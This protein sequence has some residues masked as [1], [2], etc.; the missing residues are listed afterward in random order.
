[1][2]A[3]AFIASTG[4]SQDS[5]GPTRQRY[6]PAYYFGTQG[7]PPQVVVFPPVGAPVVIPLPIPDLLRFRA[8]TRDGRQ[9]FATI[10][11]ITSPGSPGHPARLGPPRL[12]R[13]DFGP[14][15]VTPVADLVGLDDVLGLVVT[16]HQ[17][18]ILFA[19]AGWKGKIGCD[20]FE[21]DPSGRNMQLLIPDF[22]CGIGGVSPDGTKMLVRRAKDLDIIDLTTGASRPLGS[23]F[24]KGG[25]SPDGRWI[26]ALRLDPASEQPRTRYSRTVRINADDLSRQQ[27]MGGVNDEEITWSPDS[28]YLLY[29]EWNPSCGN[30]SEVGMFLTMDIETGK[31]ERVRGST[32]RVNSNPY[33]GWI[34]L[35][36]IK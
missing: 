14:V 18:K 3:V 7:D 10:N 27:V 12:V 24:W 19:G 25:W 5:P 1:M 8:F 11:T 32:C 23:G 13:V 33:D 9:I 22:G 2:G 36:A 17:D 20:L 30:K 29:S 34:S 4:V 31:R 16:P 35:D 28:R 6:A 15:R 26:A 21:I